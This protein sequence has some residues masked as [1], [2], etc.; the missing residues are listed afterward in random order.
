ML[1]LPSPLSGPDND[2]NDYVEE[3]NHDNDNNVSDDQKVAMIMTNR[4]KIVNTFYTDENKTR[5]TIKPTINYNK[6]YDKL[7]ITSVSP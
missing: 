3:D 6:T 7:P 2:D 5:Q 4:I 1:Q